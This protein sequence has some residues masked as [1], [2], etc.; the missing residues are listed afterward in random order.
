MV[1]QVGDIVLVIVDPAVNNGS[2]VAPGVLTNVFNTAAQETDD[3]GPY[4][5]VNA[6]AFLDADGADQRLTSAALYGTEDAARLARAANPES[7][8]LFAKTAEVR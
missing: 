6:K 4:Y 7:R 1:P 5:R 2:D 8:A 3:W